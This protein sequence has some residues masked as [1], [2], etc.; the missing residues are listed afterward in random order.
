MAN[1]QVMEQLCILEGRIN[2]QV[3]ALEK[4]HIDFTQV[5]QQKHL[6]TTALLRSLGANRPTFTVSTVPL[7]MHPSCQ[8]PS[9]TTD[10]QVEI[11]KNQL[12]IGR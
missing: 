7:P 10:V 12:F 9:S 6:E 4:Q 1:L 11:L 8:T 5:L 2:A 3:M